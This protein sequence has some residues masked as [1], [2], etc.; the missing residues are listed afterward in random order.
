MTQHLGSYA[1][2]IHII[3]SG[4]LGQQ[5]RPWWPRPTAIVYLWKHY[6]PWFAGSKSLLGL[7]VQEDKK[8]HA[9]REAKGFIK[10]HASLL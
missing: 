5:G 8:L 4:A 9:F 2:V 10:L 7:Y 6:L 3:P 1:K